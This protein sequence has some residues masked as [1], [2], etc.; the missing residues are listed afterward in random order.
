MGP[1]YYL[2]RGTI[3]PRKH[4]KKEEGRKEWKR[5]EKNTKVT[6]WDYRYSTLCMI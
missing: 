6:D 3:G 5:K 2:A 4:H 1:A